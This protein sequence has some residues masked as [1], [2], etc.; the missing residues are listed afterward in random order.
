MSTALDIYTSDVYIDGIEIHGIDDDSIPFPV[1]SK[2]IMDISSQDSSTVA[3]KKQK[4]LDPGAVKIAGYKIPSDL[5]QIALKSALS[6]RNLHTFQIGVPGTNDV[7]AYQGYVTEFN[8]DVKDGSYRFSAGIVL[9]GAASKSATKADI[10]SITVSST[11]TVKVPSSVTVST[12]DQ[13]FEILPGV[14]PT[15]ITVTA[16]SASGIYYSVDNGSTWISLTTGVISGDISLG[17]ALTIKNVIL[18]VL[19][20]NRIS[21]FVK[22]VFAVKRE[23]VAGD[24]SGS[25]YLFKTSDNKVFLL[26][27]ATALAVS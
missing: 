4:R 17:G 27:D 3:D 20:T 16:G 18:K 7:Y 9:S 26:S 21:R 10:T 6:D 22:L 1:S 15:H 23:F 25:G 24:F 14:N 11:G 5:G 12:T 2:G 13:I 8:A 19:Q